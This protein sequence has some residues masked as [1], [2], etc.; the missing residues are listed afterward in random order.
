MGPQWTKIAD[1][2]GSRLRIPVISKTCCYVQI[3][4]LT[5]FYAAKLRFVFK[6]DIKKNKSPIS[7]GHFRKIRKMLISSGVVCEYP[8]FLRPAARFKS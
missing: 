2:L 4:A 3:V 5:V 1:L 8:L 6:M 7:V